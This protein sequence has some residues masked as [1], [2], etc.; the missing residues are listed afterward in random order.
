MP[1]GLGVLVIAF[2][3]AL[4][5]VFVVQGGDRPSVGVLRIEKCNLNR[6]AS[7][8]SFSN[9]VLQARE[10][11]RIPPVEVKLIA[12]EQVTE[13]DASRPR[14]D[15]ASRLGP[16]GITLDELPHRFEHRAR[17][18]ARVVHPIGLQGVKILD[19]IEVFVD[20][21]AV[22]LGGSNQNGRLPVKRIVVRIGRMVLDWF[23]PEGRGDKKDRQTQNAQQFQHDALHMPKL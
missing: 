10:V 8:A 21:A 14:Q 20:Y 22:V 18:N 12:P 9:E 6:Y 13:L 19:I 2:A 7:F 17:I 4:H 11:L 3:H 23:C 1:H 16:Q 15:E 5:V